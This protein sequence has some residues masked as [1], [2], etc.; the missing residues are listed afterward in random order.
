MNQYHSKRKSTF[1]KDSHERSTKKSEDTSASFKALNLG[2]D[3]NDEKEAFVDHKKISMMEKEEK[4]NSL[5]LKKL[6]LLS[7]GTNER[8]FKVTVE[9]T[10]EEESLIN[11]DPDDEIKTI[12]E[13]D[14]EENIGESS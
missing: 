1:E 2:Y 8:N 9:Y 7:K 6:S 14:S 4:R 11:N 3:F 10:M 13:T 12:T 5:D